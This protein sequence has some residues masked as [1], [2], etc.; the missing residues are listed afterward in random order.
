VN[1][2]DRKVI[3]DTKAVIILYTYNNCLY[4]AHLYN[5]KNI[6]VSGMYA[7]KD[8]AINSVKNY[9]EVCD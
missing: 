9:E 7:T 2:T 1:L 6:I 5:G 3:I 4:V 8:E